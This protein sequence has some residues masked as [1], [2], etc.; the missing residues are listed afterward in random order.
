MSKL[1]TNSHAAG[2]PLAGEQTHKEQ[3][4][5]VGRGGY[6]R[7]GYTQAKKLRKTATIWE[8][9]LWR[10]LKSNALGVSFRRQQPVGTYIVDFISFEA[11][12]IIELD[13]SQHQQAVAR[14]GVRDAYLNARGYQVL[15]FWNNE[16]DH[17]MDEVLVKIVAALAPHQIR[18]GGFDSPARGEL[19]GEHA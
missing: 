12:L 14:D 6:E 11:R 2:S 10:Q 3:R 17:A 16:I 1:N 5:A 9:K 19:A 8:Q 13:G 4:D 7:H 18:Q 15:R